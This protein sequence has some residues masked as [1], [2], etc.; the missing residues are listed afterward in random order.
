MKYLLTTLCLLTCHL[1]LTAQHKLFY[2]QFP[3]N[4]YFTPKTQS[5]QIIGTPTLFNP[6]QQGFLV[7]ENEDT[8][9]NLELNYDCLKESVYAKDLTQTKVNTLSYDLSIEKIKY[10]NTTK[11]ILFNP[12]NAGFQPSNS[13]E[14][15]TGLV[16]LNYYSPDK[17]FILGRYYKA[18]LE[19][20]DYNPVLDTGRKEDRLSIRSNLYLF[21]KEKYYPIPNENTKIRAF[22]QS[23]FNLDSDRLKFQNDEILIQFLTDNLR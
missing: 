11:C 17:D 9:M 8:L 6:S 15:I 13:K 4:V 18:V 7:L 12:I 22:L 5:T 20:A 1:D 16:E 10:L 19:R 21:Y 14:V 3:T 2:L 23:E